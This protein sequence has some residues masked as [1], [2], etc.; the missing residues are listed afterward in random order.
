MRFLVVSVKLL[1]SVRSLAVSVRVM[2][3]ALESVFWNVCL[4][5]WA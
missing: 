4:G 3:T 2:E 1:V 5:E